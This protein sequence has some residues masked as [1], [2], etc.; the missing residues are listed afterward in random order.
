MN[1]NT[2]KS[3]VLH[4]PNEN[5]SLRFDDWFDPIEDGVRGQVRS[6]IAELIRGSLIPHC[7]VHVMAGMQRAKKRASARESLGTAM[8][9]ENAHCWGAL[10]RPILMCHA[11]G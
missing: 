9:A 4:S 2:T 3:D 8:A 1:K 11:Q 6:F 7:R 10:G 5:P